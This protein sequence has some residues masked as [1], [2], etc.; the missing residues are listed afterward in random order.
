MQRTFKREFESLEDIFAFIQEFFARE[1]I[2][3]RHLYN[4]NLAAEELFTNMVK[5]NPGNLNE[6]LISVS[7]VDNELRLSL[8][9]FDVDAF[10]VTKG[11]TKPPA[12]TLK[13]QK[14]GGLGL[15]LVRQM[16]DGITY[17]YEN[18]QSRITVTKNLR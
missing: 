16:V 15:R 2:E 13:D 18:R 14:R 9:D 1:N 10:D 12:G 5:Y 17:D 4:I 7:R 6:I 8:T 3:S 11:P